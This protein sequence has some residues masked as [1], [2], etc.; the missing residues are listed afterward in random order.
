[1][2]PFNSQ[3][4]SKI[5][6][7]G[8]STQSLHK[9]ELTASKAEKEL[10][11]RIAENAP[12]KQRKS[13]SQSFAKS[14]SSVN[15]SSSHRETSKPVGPSSQPVKSAPSGTKIRVSTSDGRQLTLS[16]NSQTTYAQLQQKI[17]QELQIPVSKQTIKYGFPPKELR[18]PT[19]EHENDPLPLYHGDRITVE[20]AEDISDFPST[21]R[22]LPSGHQSEAEPLESQGGWSKETSA[23]QGLIARLQESAG[24][25]L[26]I[27]LTSQTLIANLKKITFWEH[28]RT[29]PSLF[30]KGGL[31]YKIVER[32]LGMKDGHHCMLPGLKEHRFCY[33]KSYDRLELCL[34]PLGHFPISPDVDNL[35][36]LKDISVEAMCSSHH[37]EGGEASD[38]ESSERFPGAGQAVSSENKMEHSDLNSLVGAV[39]GVDPEEAVD[40]DMSERRRQREAGKSYISVQSKK[41]LD[42][43]RM[44]ASQEEKRVDTNTDWNVGGTKQDS[45]KVVEEESG[46]QE[47]MMDTIEDPRSP[48]PRLTTVAMDTETS[49]SRESGSSGEP[50]KSDGNIPLESRQ[51]GSSSE[52]YVTVKLGPGYT[53]LRKEEEEEDKGK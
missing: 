7:S 25:D 38:G 41:S 24:D 17:N 15:S 37:R 26:E 27:Q 16:L 11:R 35:V 42:S 8:R 19:P 46:E 47:E 30:E 5:I 52:G 45:D 36:K 40:E 32:D 53:V 28:V 12:I 44:F 33:S 18:T 4:S 20:I 31:F 48:L 14:D 2:E 23:L 43:G 34:E 21:S 10:Q 22:G 1:M 50:S 29:Q 13:P 51:E 49:T 9:E 39:G 6:L 3:Q